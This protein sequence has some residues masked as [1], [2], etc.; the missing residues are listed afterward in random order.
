MPLPL[1]QHQI[2]SDCKFSD[3]IFDK[4]SERKA[5]ELIGVLIIFYHGVFQNFAAVGTLRQNKIERVSENIGYIVKSY[6]PPF[7]LGE[8]LV[9]FLHRRRAIIINDDKGAEH[10]RGFFFVALEKF[11]FRVAQRVRKILAEAV[12]LTR[13]TGVVKEGHPVIE[14]VSRYL[15][16]RRTERFFG[17]LA[18][19]RGKIIADSQK[20][21]RRAERIFHDI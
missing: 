11:A 9:I 12:A 16:D 13:K 4:L 10:S 17:L 15:F 20:R 21:N 1:Y 7:Q 3:N 5:C 18:F 6:Y 2:G 14:A 8:H 19:G